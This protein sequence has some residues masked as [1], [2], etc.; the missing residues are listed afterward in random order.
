MTRWT[1]SNKAE[2]AAKVGDL[3]TAGMRPKEIAATLGKT[4]RRILQIRKLFCLP[5]WERLG[6]IARGGVPPQKT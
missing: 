6:K 5:D 3:L 2:L 4:Q 1:R